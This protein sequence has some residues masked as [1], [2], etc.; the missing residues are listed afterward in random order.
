MRVGPHHVEETGAF[1]GEAHVGEA[2]IEQTRPG[3]RGVCVRQGADQ[4][5]A[6]EAE[7]AGRECGDETAVAREVVR[8]GRVTHPCTAGDRT[9]P[10]PR[11]ALLFDLGLRSL[12]Q[13]L[14]EIPR[15]MSRI[16]RHTKRFARGIDSVNCGE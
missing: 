15:E 9:E 5:A 4:L 8:R 13:G 16:R 1:D 12:E 2:Q 6:E 10:E 11:E 7:G 14:A 3:I